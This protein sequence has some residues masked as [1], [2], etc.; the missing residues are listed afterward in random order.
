MIAALSMLLVGACGDD[1]DETTTE[2]TTDETTQTT[3]SDEGAAADMVTI[4]GVDYAYE[5]VPES[6]A[7]GSQIVLDNASD[8][9]VHEILAFRLPDDEERPVSELVQL[10]EEEL[11]ALFTA[12]PIVALAPPGQDS[13]SVPTPPAVLEEPGRYGF[14][15]F[16]PTGAPPDEVMQA[17][18]DFIAAGGDDPAGPQYPQT[19][20]PHVAGGMFAEVV[21]E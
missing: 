9:E 17:V 10:P 13:T 20:P 11:Q 16:I 2:D 12:E 5:N 1:D 14:F 4:T 8:G 3:E 6:I 19:G 7:A 18:Q 21:V 15:C